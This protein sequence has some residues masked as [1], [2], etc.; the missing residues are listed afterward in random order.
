MREKPS[1]NCFY[2]F[3]FYFFEGFFNCKITDFLG[4]FLDSTKKVSYIVFCLVLYLCQCVMCNVR[5]KYFS[6]VFIFNFRCSI[7]VKIRHLFYPLVYYFFPKAEFIAF[8]PILIFNLARSPS[9]PRPVYASR[10]VLYF[11]FILLALSSVG[12][13]ARANL[14]IFF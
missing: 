11:L 14:T 10:C 6:Y 4:H 8:E 2:I 5:V 7:F 13:F 3:I 9:N 12:A 1:Q